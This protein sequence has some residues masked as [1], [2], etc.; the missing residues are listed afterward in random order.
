MIQAIKTIVGN[1][2]LTSAMLSEDHGRWSPRSHSPLRGEDEEAS[3][4]GRTQQERSEQNR[5]RVGTEDWVG[6]RI[7]RTGQKRGVG[8]KLHVEAW[9]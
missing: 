6:D 7:R 1:L 8:Y 4:S 3:R 2:T 5:K 9:L